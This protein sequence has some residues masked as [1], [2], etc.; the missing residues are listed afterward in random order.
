MPEAILFPLLWS[1]DLR[2]SWVRVL[3]LSHIHIIHFFPP[4]KQETVNWVNPLPLIKS[5]TDVSVGED[6]NR[7]MELVIKK[8]KTEGQTLSLK[9]KKCLS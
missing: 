5:F 2:P 7:G 3:Q 1:G 9:R 8:N 4:L 6:L